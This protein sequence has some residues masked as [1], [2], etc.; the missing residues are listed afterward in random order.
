M[1]FEK[2]I[3]KPSFFGV[4]LLVPLLFAGIFLSWF[5]FNLSSNLNILAESKYIVNGTSDSYPVTL[6]LSK[7]DYIS[8]SFASSKLNGRGTGNIR[9]DDANGKSCQYVANNPRGTLYYRIR[10]TDFLQKE[11]DWS[12]ITQLY[13]DVNYHSDFSGQYTDI[14]AETSSI[15]DKV[16]QSLGRS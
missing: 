1:S 9:F 8:W 2:Q 12:N 7:Y 16:S 14:K 3:L 11:C 6:D 5:A 4:P 15:K 10:K 13:L